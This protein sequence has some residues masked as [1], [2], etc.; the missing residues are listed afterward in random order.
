MPSP[1]AVQFPINMTEVT[2]RLAATYVNLYGRMP[3]KPL[4]AT[5]AGIIGVENAGGVYIWD[6]NVGNITAPAG[7]DGRTWEANGLTFIS[8]TSIYEGM[9]YWWEF[10]RLHYRDVL[11]DADQGS[12]DAAVRDLFRLG[13]VGRVTT[14]A[15]ESDYCR[16]VKAYMRKVANDADVIVDQVKRPYVGEAIAGG[17]LVVAGFLGFL[18]HRGMA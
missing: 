7:F 6:G 11:V 12:P 4:L 3:S 9:T 13:Y 15:Q 16:G 17:G 8:F 18:A 5:C 2:A 1:G 14:S 10:M